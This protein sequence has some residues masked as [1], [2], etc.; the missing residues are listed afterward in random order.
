MAVTNRTRTKHEFT[1]LRSAIE[2]DKAFMGN[3]AIITESINPGLKLIPA[4]HTDGYQGA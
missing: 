3:T 4:T 2:Y 1:Y